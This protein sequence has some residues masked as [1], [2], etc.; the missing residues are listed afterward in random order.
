MG[1]PV[2]NDEQTTTTFRTC[3][4]R[5]ELQTTRRVQFIDLTEL[6]VERVRRA[7]IHFGMLNLQTRHTTTAVVLNENEPGLLHDFEERLEAWAPRELPYR[8]NDLHAR[9]FQRLSAH[10]T[11][12]G[13]AHHRALLLGSSLTLNVVA[14]KLELGEWQRLF[15]VELDGPRERALSILMMGAGADA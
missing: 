15:V 7:R 6:A 14:G 11:P 5:I 4:D 9:R 2:F 3:H 12:N 10:E 8:H 13:D 1:L